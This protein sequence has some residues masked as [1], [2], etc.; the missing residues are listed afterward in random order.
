MGVQ[1]PV[2]ASET[3]KD[4]PPKPQKVKP[5]KVLPTDRMTCATG[6]EILR[7]YVA[8]SGPTLNPVT[9]QEVA[10]VVKL[11]KSTPSLV[12]NFFV[13]VGFLVRHEK[14]LVP[15][16]NVLEFAR[17]YAW[18]PDTATMKLAP[19]LSDNW[20]WKALSPRLAFSPLSENE[21][22]AILADAAT[23]TPD[24]KGQLR[25]I[26]DYLEAVRLIAREGG[27]IRRVEG[28]PPPAG[29]NIPAANGFASRGDEPPPPPPRV[30]EESRES[31]GGKE[32][33]SALLNVLD[34]STPAD[35]QES[36]WNVIRFL[37]GAKKRPTT[38]VVGEKGGDRSEQT[39]TDSGEPR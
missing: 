19:L 38:P 24:H 21:A 36:L 23:A 33:A 8:A 27:Q 5:A 32:L 39:K 18:N 13:D 1:K 22:V 14:G 7:A 10:D 28:T 4:G 35:V 31:P 15:T 9:N 29:N 17:S 20:F 30:S 37:R 2:T 34:E 16:K 11:H 3:L 26:L 25:V 6:L 12:N